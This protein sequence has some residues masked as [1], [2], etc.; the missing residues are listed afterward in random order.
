[1][2]TLPCS[3]RRLLKG[4]V[5]QFGVIQVVGIAGGELHFDDGRG[6][7]CGGGPCC[8]G[9]CSG[10]RVDRPM[11][12]GRDTCW[13]GV[14]IRH[15]QRH[16]RRCLHGWR[17]QGRGRGRYRFWR[18]GLSGRCDVGYGGRRRRRR[19]RG[20]DFHQNLGR[21]HHFDHPMQQAGLQRP[22]RAQVQ[23]QHTQGDCQIAAHRRKIHHVEPM[24]RVRLVPKAITNS[25]VNV[26]FVV[27]GSTGRPCLLA[28]RWVGLREPWCVATRHAQ[29]SACMACVWEVGNT[30]A[31][32]YDHGRCPRL[33]HLPLYSANANHSH[34]NWHQPT[35]VQPLRRCACGATPV[36]SHALTW[37]VNLLCK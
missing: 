7:R 24:T 27:H 25:M 15:G 6:C 19:R 13:G 35:D 33:W 30:F 3:P 21:Q 34:F 8:A 37:C 17:F 16:W 20:H 29:S 32:T 14:G 1:M 18:T 4:G 12:R 22:Q 26:S 11:G 23:H 36:F 10:R 31:Y 9:A 28:W 5:G 2:T